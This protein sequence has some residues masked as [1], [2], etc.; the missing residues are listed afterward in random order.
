M[1]RV[2]KLTVIGAAIAG[3]AVGTVAFIRSRGAHKAELVDYD[4]LADAAGEAIES[5]KGAAAESV[6]VAAAAVADAADA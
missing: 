4:E 6:D 1:N 3:A 5:G 2:V